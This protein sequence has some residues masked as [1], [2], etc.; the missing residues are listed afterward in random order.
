MLVP[1]VA[2]VP[3]LTFGAPFVIMRNTVRGRQLEQRRFEA[4]ML[5]TVLACFWSLMSGTVMVRVIEHVI[6]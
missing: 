3:L 2:A 1:A 6:G 4:A 5:A